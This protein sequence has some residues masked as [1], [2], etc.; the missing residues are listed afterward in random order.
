MANENNYPNWFLW[1]YENFAIV[2]IL[3][4]LLLAVCGIGLYVMESRLSDIE[5]QLTFAPPRSYSPPNLD[6]Y[7]AGDVTVDQLTSKHVVYVPVY[8][9][10]YY[11]G[12]SAY[13]L[14]STLSVRNV[15][16]D[17]PIF[18]E[19]IEYYDTDGKLAKNPVDRL[20]KLLPLQTLEFVIERRDSTGGSG[21]NFLIRWGAESDVN[22]PIIETVMVGTTGT[23]GISFAR[24][25]TEISVAQ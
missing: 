18:I 7:P 13:S 17:A 10:I 3:G 12:G 21:A 11:Q 6:D 1:F 9:H 24:S 23:Q 5:D 25:G 4:A 14:E 8:S 15:N 22:A 20:I 16:T 2:L 19:S